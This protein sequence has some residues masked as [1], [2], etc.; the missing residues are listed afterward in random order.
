MA[1]GR[2]ADKQTDK[3]RDVSTNMELSAV[4]TCNPVHPRGIIGP[5]VVADQFEDVAE[6]RVHLLGCH[7]GDQVVAATRTNNRHHA[8]PAAL[9]LSVCAKTPHSFMQF[10]PLLLRVCA[11]YFS[12]LHTLLRF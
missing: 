7:I 9:S 4:Q 12:N 1:V 5:N 10:F 8:F 6:H 2:Q 11:V 3:K